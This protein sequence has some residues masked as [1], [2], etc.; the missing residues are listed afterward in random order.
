MAFLD[1]TGLA[2]VRDLV[3]EDIEA[4]QLEGKD[5]KD[6]T[7]GVTFTPSLDTEGN[8]SWT[9][10]G[11]LD[12]PE[13]VNIKGPKGEDA[14]VDT[15]DILQAVYPVGALY[16]SSVAA[17]PATLFGFGTWEQIK[18]TFL[19]AAGDTYAAGTTGGE[20]THTHEYRLGV[21]TYFGSPVGSDETM[22][23]S[24][25]YT[26]GAYKDAE[27]DGNAGNPKINTGLNGEN[28]DLGDDCYQQKVVGNTKASEN[29]P[30]YLAV[31]VW[32]R[33]A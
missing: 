16:L 29:M 5:G 32:K 3:R 31:Y 15:L 25:D 10:D 7:N 12:N 1:E 13:T 2:H 14:S 30:P 4:A 19:L 24:W 26:T 23:Q 21:K 20:A 27:R 11:G 8:L 22:F 9:N 33:T 6:G 28:Q 17:D 18:D